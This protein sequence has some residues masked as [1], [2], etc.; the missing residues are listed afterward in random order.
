M[1]AKTHDPPGSWCPAGAGP[2]LLLRR[3]AEGRVRLYC[4]PKLRQGL[5]EGDTQR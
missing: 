1:Q 3:T 4:T 5:S 2:R